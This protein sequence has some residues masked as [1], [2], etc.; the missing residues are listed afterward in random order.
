MLGQGV[1]SSPCV[2]S[3][4]PTA[5]KP[6]KLSSTHAISLIIFVKELLK[7]KVCCQFVALSLVTAL[8]PTAT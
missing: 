3:P 6:V 8:L 2:L 4:Y 7:E 5:I 1:S